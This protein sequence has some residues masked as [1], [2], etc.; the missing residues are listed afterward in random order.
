LAASATVMFHEHIV[1]AE[2]ARDKP[3]ARF[4][5]LCLG[6]FITAVAFIGARLSYFMAFLFVPPSGTVL[7]VDGDKAR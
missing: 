3:C 1:A 4:R 6:I 7:P 5:H 2:I